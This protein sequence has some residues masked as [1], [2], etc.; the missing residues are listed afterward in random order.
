MRIR[1]VE[2]QGEIQDSTPLNAE[3]DFAPP[4]EV[5]VI[6]AF[7]EFDV[8]Y[9][10]CLI[11]TAPHL[12]VLHSPV[13]INV[14]RMG[15]LGSVCKNIVSDY[16]WWLFVELEVRCRVTEVQ[17]MPNEIL[18]AISAVVSETYKVRVVPE[19]CFQTEFHQLRMHEIIRVEEK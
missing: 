3:Q 10:I 1:V 5:F 13:S 11:H 14:F 15:I 17:E 9:G 7:N 12:T 18:C 6:D 8:T 19:H 4:R 16:I 2:V